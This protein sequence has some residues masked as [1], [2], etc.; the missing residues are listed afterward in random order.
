MAE[1]RSALVGGLLLAVVVTAC[2]SSGTVDISPSS[3]APGSTVVVRV[4][5]LQPGSKPETVAV[6]V[7]DKA[8]TV[9]RVDPRAGVEFLVPDH[10]PGPAPVTVKIAGRQMARATLDVRPAPAQQLVLSL[11]D[12]QVSLISSRGATHLDR[13]S[14]ET[15]V[16]TGLAYDVW[17]PDGRLV[18][19]GTLPHP[20]LGRR[21]VFEPDKT[22]HG[23]AAGKTATFTLRIPA[24]PK[25]SVVRFYEFAPGTDLSTLAGR[26][27]RRFLSEIKVGGEEP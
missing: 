26:A 20:L 10:G 16:R 21:E 13:P 2:R 1:H 7:G 11:T 15:P 8:A 3:A 12:G 22:M 14:R 19:T 6:S 18:A 25:E 27:S 4:P 5:G 17:T 24:V 9:E 23:A